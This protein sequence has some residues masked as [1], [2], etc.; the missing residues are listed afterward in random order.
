[1][2]WIVTNYS[3][4]RPAFVQHIVMKS[5]VA[6][7]ATIHKGLAILT[8]LYAPLNAVLH[9]LAWDGFGLSAGITLVEIAYMM[10]GDLIGVV[11]IFLLLRIA[12]RG[13]NAF[14]RPSRV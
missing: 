14:K 9:A 1:M 8:F 5:D 7:P 13:I 6:S 12:I 11:L 4:D 3:A 2:E 10:L